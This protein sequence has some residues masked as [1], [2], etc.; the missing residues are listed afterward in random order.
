MTPLNILLAAAPA[1]AESPIDKLAEHP[2]TL[3]PSYEFAK[4]ILETIDK[5][6]SLI[7]LGGERWAQETVYAVVIGAIALGIGMLIRWALLAGVRKLVRVRNS[8][9]GRELLKERT[10]SKCSHIIP[11]LIFMGLIPFAFNH[12]S[13][14]LWTLMRFMGIYTIVAFAIGFNA[15]L[16]FAFNRYDEHENTRNLPL[17]GI[18]NVAHGIVWIIVAILSI[19]ILLDKSPTVLLAGL[20]A[21]AAALM[22]IFKNSILGLVAGVQLS[23]NDMLHV[24]DWIVVPGTPANGTVLDVSLTTV[25][26]YNW[27][28][29]IVT[30]PPYN[31]ISGA[32]QNWRGMK[33]SGARRILQNFT[34]D[35]YA[36]VTDALLENVSN[37]YP[38][39]KDYIQ[40]LRTSGTGGWAVE[41]GIRPL[42][43]TIETNIGLYRAYLCQYLMN[44]PH[45]A[46]DQRVM[47]RFT[48][49][50]ENGYTLQIWC[51]TNTTDF[52]A[53]EGIQSAVM[54]HVAITLGDFG[55]ELYNAG[56][57]TIDFDGPLHYVA[58]APAAAA[59]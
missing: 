15:V 40:R 39:M 31:L 57:E 35:G 26:V 47:V 44:N 4:G 3:I 7:G 32:F 6:L 19:S 41:G 17:R 11:P 50:N 51:F 1:V 30:V 54:E 49:S 45:I 21:F 22:L 2:H 42:N 52:N 28:N 38:E 27:D 14:V 48:G 20:G 18:L 13:S 59:K 5:G 29:T 34:V 36:P 25:K 10:L 43:G 37:K 46:K 33:D 58:A 9:F 55:L 23:Q 56:E 12:H 53:Y 24:G 8:E 16:T